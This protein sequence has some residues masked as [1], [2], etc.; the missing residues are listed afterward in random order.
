M[1]QLTLEINGLKAKVEPGTTILEAAQDLGIQIPTL[2]FHESLSPYG[3]CGLC[4]VELTGGATQRRV[5]A[6]AY[7]VEEGMEVLTDSPKVIAT[8]RI[9][10]EMYL[11][12][13]PA[14]KLVGDLARK[15]G[16]QKP[17][18]APEEDACVVCGRCVRFCND[19]AGAYAINFTKRGVAHEVTVFPE[20]S[21]V[22]CVGCT[23]C[24]DNCPGKLF[25]IDLVNFRWH[26]ER[27]PQT[28]IPSRKC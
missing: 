25:T 18:F 13:S 6:C 28:L 7:P 10:V 22:H 26:P 4:V 11:A 27:Q 21:A 19:V 1:S 23:A 17:R 12:K 14:I 2:C 24:V 20:I 16:I 5:L 15:Y 8:R 3:A 9:L